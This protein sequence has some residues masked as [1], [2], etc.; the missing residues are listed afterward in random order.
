MMKN[1]KTMKIII[2]SV[3][4][5][6]VISIIAVLAI[7]LIP[8]NS[9]N[10]NNNNQVSEETNTVAENVAQD[11]NTVDQEGEDTQ[12]VEY[13][14]TSDGSKIPLPKGFTYVEGTVST[15]AVIKDEKGNEFVWVPT[16]NIV[17]ARR[18]FENPN[19]NTSDEENTTNIGSTNEVEV[20]EANFSE[21]AESNAEYM[22]SVNKYRGFYIGRYEA[23]QDAEDE[24][25]ASTV[26][27]AVPLTEI[28]YD[29]MREIAQNTYA[30]SS[31]VKSDITSSF[32]WDTLCKWLENS[33]YDIYNSTSYGNYANNIEGTKSKAVTGRN[34]KWVTN[35]IYDLAGNVWEIST[36]EWGDIYEKNHSGRGGGFH[37]DGINYPIS[38]RVAEY[39]G[40]Y[41]YIGFRLV[42]YLK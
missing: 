18:T 10:Q 36:E 40:A 3:A 24:N 5:V 2:I 12:D 14:E 13:V 23:S 42:L 34:S 26:S 31:S 29:R 8:K 33:G 1:N 15:G 16:D 20:A 30:D 37:N 41:T 17:F 9:D 39:D 22:D 35:N 38:C 19:T 6:L 7:V 25:K 11:E 28:V 32:V 27:G 4:I 21:S